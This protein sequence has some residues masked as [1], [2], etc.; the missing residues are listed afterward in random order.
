MGLILKSWV[1]LLALI[2]VAVTFSL[3]S[4]VAANNN[5]GA[6]YRIQSGDTLYISVWREDV[7]NRELQVL[8]D[9][10]VSFPL[11]GRVDVRDRTTTQVEDAVA[12]RL[13]GYIND[14]V[15][16]VVVTALEGNRVYVLG[17]VNQPGAVILDAPMTAAQIIARSGGL[18]AFA[19]G[20][21]VRVLR[22]SGGE[23]QVFDV[24]YRDIVRGKKL[25]T[26][27]TLQP[28]DT[29]VVP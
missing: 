18:T 15:V 1:R 29:V 25:D 9:G 7:L 21:R 23:E 8:P 11:A 6:A 20:N 24:R 19:K 26:D 28:G 10:S 27:V 2:F 22:R 16:S 4:A 5:D 12:S 3:G 14:P 13:E 17:E